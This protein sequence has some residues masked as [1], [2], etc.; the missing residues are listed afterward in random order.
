MYVANSFSNFVV[1]A[2]HHVVSSSFSLMSACWVACTSLI[3]L[4]L[5]CLFEET[6]NRVIVTLNHLILLLLH[7]WFS[8]TSM[9]RT[10]S[11]NWSAIKIGWLLWSRNARTSII[12]WTSC[13]HLL[14]CWALVGFVLIICCSTWIL[15][16]HIWIVIG[17]MQNDVWWKAFN[18]PFMLEAILRCHSYL[19]VPLKAP[20]NKVYKRWIRRLSQFVHN[21][22]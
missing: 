12:I 9:D 20:A 4:L 6:I 15:I 1:R 22:F 13:W 3:L 18:N 2:N 21:V 11:L 16:S 10:L 17:V 19:W 8:L 7:R 5:A 14:R